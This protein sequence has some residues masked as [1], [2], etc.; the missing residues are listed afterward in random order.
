MGENGRKF[1]VNEFSL[2][3][4]AIRHE[5]FYAKTLNKLD[6]RQKNIEIQ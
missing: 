5:K 4:L 1:V 2:E 3:S 6:L